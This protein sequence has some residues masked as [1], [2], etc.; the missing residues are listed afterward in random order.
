M[1]NRTLRIAAKFALGAVLVVTLAADFVA[2]HGYGEQFR[3]SPGAAPSAQFPLGTDELGR[4]RL[5]R[6]IHG[7]R[8]SLVLAPAAALVAVVI[9]AL[10]STAAG[11][12]GGFTAQAATVVT[13]LF[14]SLPGLFLLLAARAMLPLNAGPW[15][16]VGITFLLLGLLGWAA[17]AR[18]IRASVSA[19]KDSNFLL[20]ARAMG[21]SP[22]RQLTVHVAA[23]LRPLAKAQF[24][25]LAPAFIIAE[26]NLSLLGLGVAEPLPSLG[27][28]LREL[29]NYAAIGDQ[30][31]LLAPAALLIG[32]LVCLQAASP[33][34]TNS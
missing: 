34:E 18:V 29:E 27:N 28:L 3:E 10:A 12:F 1:L 32:V 14:L 4:D 25:L 19:M 5:S 15:A 21:C 26:A 24:W 22:W 31:A 11:W 8:V 33:K 23:N 13:D 9:A 6:L 17:S 16:S 7:A 30:P 2:P 20:Q